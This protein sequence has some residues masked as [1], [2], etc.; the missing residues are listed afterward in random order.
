MQCITAQNIILHSD[1]GKQSLE[2]GKEDEQ[3]DDNDDVEVEDVDEK[4]I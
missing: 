3:D 1:A 2:E 4:S